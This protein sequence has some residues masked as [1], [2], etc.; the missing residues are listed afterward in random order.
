[1]MTNS[2]TESISTYVAQSL[3]LAL[4]LEVS[5]EKPGNVHR[6]AGFKDTRYEHFLASAVAVT[7]CF[8]RAAERGVA[9]SRGRIELK[10][11][12]IGEL[13]RNAVE[14][15][16]KWQHGGNTILGATTMLLPI[17][18]AAGMTYANDEFSLG[19]LKRNIGLVIKSTTPADAVAFYAAVDI[20][21]PGGMGRVP[22]FDV[23]DP[24]SK[25]RILEK[26]ASLY[27][28]FKIASKYDSIASEWVNN[29][30]LTF[31]IGY[32][33]LISQLRETDDMNAAV[34]QTFLKIL[35]EVP[36]TLIQ[37]K[38]GREK[39]EEVSTYAKRVLDA[40][41]LKT[42]QGRKM[43]LDLDKFLRDPEH[44]LNP[45][46]TADIVSA[47]LAVVILEGYRP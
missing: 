47:V 33:F 21:K 34:V 30:P 38:V 19:K 22:E 4:L 11:I 42:S 5:S 1:M 39:A 25:R 17:A 45:G 10:D 29:Y 9:T 6:N 41:G 31:N 24:S 46:T 18:V 23:T 15:A 16:M 26:H 13:I 44:K 7:P 27:D 3:Q 40:G 37:R 8:K 12:G 2:S 20:A 36:D 35:S 32:R 14:S 43:L 28:L